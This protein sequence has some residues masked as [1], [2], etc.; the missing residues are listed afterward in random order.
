MSRD[1]RV[2]YT[3]MVLNESLLEVLREKPLSRITVKEIVV[4][5]ISKLCQ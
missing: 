4:S 2:K 1:R 3:Q 5:Y